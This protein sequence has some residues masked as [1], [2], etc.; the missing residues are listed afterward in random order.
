MSR[1]GQE[2][3]HLKAQTKRDLQ[4]IE[5]IKDNFFIKIYF[6]YWCNPR[7]TEDVNFEN[8]VRERV[9]KKIHPAFTDAPI[10]K[11]ICG[12]INENE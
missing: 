8:A 5:T 2:A 4:R 1:V 10:S 7:F 9:A 3:K 11:R 6:Y 12:K